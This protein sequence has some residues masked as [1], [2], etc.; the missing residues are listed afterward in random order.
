MLIQ[1]EDKEI[2]NSQLKLELK[3]LQHKNQ[4]YLMSAQ[5]AINDADE[6]LQK[7]S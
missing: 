2:E 3:I 5:N 7:I 1:N 4:N 6:G